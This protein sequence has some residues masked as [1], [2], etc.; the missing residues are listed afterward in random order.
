VAP[1]P[2]ELGLVQHTRFPPVT[3]KGKPGHETS[4]AGKVENFLLS[5]VKTELLARL[6][7]LLDFDP[8][9]WIRHNWSLLSNKGSTIIRQGRL[10]DAEKRMLADSGDDQSALDQ[11]EYLVT[12]GT[13]R[14]FKA[15]QSVSSSSFM[16]TF[17]DAGKR[18]QM[19]IF[20]VAVSDEISPSAFSLPWFACPKS[21]AAKATK[22]K[23]VKKGSSKVSA[24]NVSSIIKEAEEILLDAFSVCFSYGFPKLFQDACYG[25]V[26]LKMF[27]IY[28]LKGKADYQ[29]VLWEA[30][31]YL[32]ECSEVND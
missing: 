14:L 2:R 12:Y 29:H 16:D 32:R 1:T 15:M 22:S 5:Y 13:L 31:F 8:S 21:P 19:P 6:G 11:A 23:T 10:P 7:R 20:L 3:A 18:A 25:L 26:V 30:A 4:V 17:F 28:S 9:S 24:L 27:E